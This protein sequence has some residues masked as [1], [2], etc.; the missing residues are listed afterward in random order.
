[1]ANKSRLRIGGALTALGLFAVGLVGG[2]EGKRNAAYRDI[3]GVWTICYGE[4]RGV[5]K[6]DYRTDAQCDAMLANALVD[7]EHGM[8]RCLKA[9]DALPG[10]MYVA[11]VSATYNL[12]MGA[13]CKSSMARLANAGDLEGSCQALML[14]V[15][16]RVR[17]VLRKI[18]G[19]VYRR[20]IER[21]ICLEA[22]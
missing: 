12:G 10:K 20:D 9:P 11:M 3:V 15:N 7:Y 13:F 21:D 16:G 6:N 14:Y 1:M 4:T 18:K 5:R 17:G 2:L 22:I 19:L 8:R